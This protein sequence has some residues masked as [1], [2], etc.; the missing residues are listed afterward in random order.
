MKL[1]LLPGLDGTGL[2][3]KP[4]LEALPSELDVSVISYPHDVL[5]SYEELVEYVD[6]RL[7][8][9][10]YILIAESF[11]GP[12]AY[13]L[14]QRKPSHL[15]SIVF[16][17]TFLDS[18]RPLLSRLSG[19]FSP[20]FIRFMPDLIIKTVLLGSAANKEML[21]LFK[22]SLKKVSPK[23]LSFRLGELSKL[24]K[25]NHRQDQKEDVS[26]I[27]I[28]ASNDNLVLRKS[29][30][31]FKK[32]FS[33]LE[34]SKVEGSHFILQTNPQACSKIITNHLQVLLGT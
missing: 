26:A 31:D 2:L 21:R 18:L 19:L 8:E 16:V 20:S 17:A 3:F 29:A 1:V 7:P 10:D 34:I 25:L 11:A 33:R 4:L 24:S 9:E 27:Y 22:E 15:K 32:V 28:Q 14:V 12:I 13:Q 5:M 6:A 23:V 30:E